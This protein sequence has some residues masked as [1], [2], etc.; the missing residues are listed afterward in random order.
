MNVSEI[1]DDVV[2]NSE[3]DLEDITQFELVLIQ[4]WNQSVRR[5]KTQVRRHD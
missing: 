4:F 2:S 1:R 3:S 5:R